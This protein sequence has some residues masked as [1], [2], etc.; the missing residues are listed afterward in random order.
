M[1]MMTT[2]CVNENK[3]DVP[4]LELGVCGGNLFPFLARLTYFG[5]FFF[6]VSYLSR[7]VCYDLRIHLSSIYFLAS[8][9][10]PRP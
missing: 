2:T 3:M 9:H 7:D 1:T 4:E 5:E 6:A 10:E 8:S